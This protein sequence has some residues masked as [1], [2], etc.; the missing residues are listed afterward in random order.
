MPVKVEPVAHKKSIL[1]IQRLSIQT[2]L[3]TPVQTMSYI[4]ATEEER[5]GGGTNRQAGMGRR[6]GGVAS[7]LVPAKL[8]AKSCRD[9]STAVSCC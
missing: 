4:Q 5:T 9:N 7:R 2:I 1:E 6:A 3:C 8:Q